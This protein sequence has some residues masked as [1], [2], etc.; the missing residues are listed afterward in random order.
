MNR[1][2]ALRIIQYAVETT[3]PRWIQYSES[4]K[5]IDSVFILR[6][7]EQQGFQLFKM[8][9][10]LERFNLLSIN[11]L[12]NILSKCP[13]IK[14]YSRHFAGSLTSEFYI[15]LKNGTCGLEGEKF[16]EAIKLFLNKKIGSPG[17]TFWKLLYQLLQSCNYLKQNYSGCFEKYLLKKY[18]AYTKQFG[19]TEEDLLKLSV[20]E[21]EQFLLKAKPWNELIGIGPNMFDFI[22][23][24]F[25]EAQF[26]INSFK[27]DS[28][29]QYFLTTTGIAKL[30]DPFDRDTTITFIRSLKMHF[31]LREINKG[32]Y[33]FCS[34]TESNNFGFCHDLCKCSICA[35]NTIC[36]KNF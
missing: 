5:Y 9:P 3:K 6:G 26:V 34:K 23:G 7:Y 24:D 18:Q 31:N 33:T 27:F 15:N 19:L 14:T 11:A 35:V 12:G 22:M 21:W 17:R 16:F 36:E 13:N 8:R 4:W 10:I 2:N 25:V 20:N 30:L 29:N 32:I 1:E 28:S